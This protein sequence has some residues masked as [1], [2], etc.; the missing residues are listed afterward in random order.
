MSSPLSPLS[1]NIV[2]WLPPFHLPTKISL[3]CIS[4]FYLFFPREFNFNFHDVLCHPHISYAST[5]FP[6]LQLTRSSV[7]FLPLTFILQSL[8][9]LYLNLSIGTVFLDALLPVFCYP[10]KHSLNV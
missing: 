5:S 2:P 9:D 4:L 8:N 3:C 6:A 1:N 7:I 10:P